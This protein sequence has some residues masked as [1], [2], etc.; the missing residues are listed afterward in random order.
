MYNNRSKL[1]VDIANT[2]N[3][4]LHVCEAQDLINHFDEVIG[5]KLYLSQ[6]Y[7]KVKYAY[8]LFKHFSNL[9]KYDSNLNAD[10]SDMTSYTT[11]QLIIFFIV[12]KAYE[13]KSYMTSCTIIS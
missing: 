7:F 2:K 4:A 10:M 1:L 3:A 12:N 8:I 13:D 5:G 6:V 9:T 11:I